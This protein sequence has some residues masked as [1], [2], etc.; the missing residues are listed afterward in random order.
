[1]AKTW[2]K[3]LRQIKVGVALESYHLPY[4]PGRITKGLR[5]S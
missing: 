3:E 4:A 5:F 2:Q 1:M